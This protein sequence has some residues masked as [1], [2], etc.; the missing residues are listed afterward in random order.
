MYVTYRYLNR[1]ERKM[2]NVE[3]IFANLK[4][5]LISLVGD[6]SGV[7]NAVDDARIA[8]QPHLPGVAQVEVT[9]VKEVENAGQDDE[10]EGDTTNAP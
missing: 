10:N 7:H 6:L 4:K 2:S 1:K 5:E 3:E 9:Q 8:L